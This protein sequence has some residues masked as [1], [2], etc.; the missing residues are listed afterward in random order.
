MLRPPT[1][2]QLDDLVAKF[3]SYATDGVIVRADPSPVERSER[4]HLEL[5]RLSL[6]FNRRQPGRLRQL[7]DAV[8]GW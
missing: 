5:A 8:N 1:D 7:I 4:D 2:T 6:L 3:G